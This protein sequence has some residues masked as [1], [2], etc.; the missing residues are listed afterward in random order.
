L[1][2]NE[3]KTGK[4]MGTIRTVHKAELIH[5]QQPAH[6]R[7]DI[8]LEGALYKMVRNMVG[9]SLDVCRGRLTE[10]DFQALLHPTENLSRRNNK[11]KPAPPE[12]LS[13]EH[14]FYPKDDDF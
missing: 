14:V 11:S 12:G 5:E 9:T 10:K 1:E 3:R 6:Y 4:P 8:H 13:L 7:I 2:Q